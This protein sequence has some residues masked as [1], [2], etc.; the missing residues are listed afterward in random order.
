MTRT[1]RRVAFASIT[2]VACTGC[3][4]PPPARSGALDYLTRKGCE[5]VDDA[6]VKVKVPARIGVALPPAETSDA[7]A[8]AGLPPTAH[9]VAATTI[10]DARRQDLVTRVVDS[11]RQR[12]GIGPVQ[13]VPTSYL[14]AGGGF[15]ELGRAG[16]SFGFDLVAVVSWDQF[17]FDGEGRA[18]FDFGTLEGERAVEG[19]PDETVT[20]MDAALFDVATRALLVRVAGDSRVKASKIAASTPEGLRD[21]SL[22]GFDDALKDLTGKLDAAMTEFTGKLAKGP[23]PGLGMHEYPAPEPEAPAH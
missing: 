17:R 15:A 5:G 11:I 1:W 14:S 16:S 8:K 12:E 20:V 13:V 7:A 9:R 6:D 19:G 22:A 21:T 18:A 10:P 2:G 3:F 23:V 4:S